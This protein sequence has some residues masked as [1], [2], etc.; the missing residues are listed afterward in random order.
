MD[1]PEVK[2]EV[3]SDPVVEVMEPAAASSELQQ[4][5]DQLRAER[6]ELKDLVQRSRAEFDNYRRRVEREKAEMVDHGASDA[7]RQVLAVVDDF[8][9][10][11]KVETQD[12]EYARGIEMIH[13]R[14]TETLKKLGL[15]PIEALGQTFDPNVHYAVEMSPT[16]EAADQTILAEYQKGFYFKGKLLRPAMVKVAVKK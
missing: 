4:E 5:L 15:T 1:T 6:D 16:D 13:Q 7:V 11:L 2:T 9:R 8:D 12:K 10:A 3:A 14:F